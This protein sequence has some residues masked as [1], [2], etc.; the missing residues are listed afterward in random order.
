MMQFLK[1]FLNFAD[2]HICFI[3][4]LNLM[5]IFLKNPIY[6]LLCFIFAVINIVAIFIFFEADFIALIFFLVYVGA[7]AVLFLALIMFL[8]LSYLFYTDSFVSKNKSVNNYLY[9]CLFVILVIFSINEVIT[10]QIIIPQISNLSLHHFGISYLSYLMYEKNS[11]LIIF[12]GFLLF[13]TTIL[14]LA[15]TTLPRFQNM[16]V[17]RNILHRERIYLKILD[18]EIQNNRTK[19]ASR[20]INEWTEP[21]Y[22]LFE[23]FI[24]YSPTFIFIG[25]SFFVI[26]VVK[27]D[28]DIFIFFVD[29]AISICLFAIYMFVILKAFFKTN[30]SKRKLF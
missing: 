12:S 22:T 16:D 15:Y 17:V 19:N 24:L 5:V 14:T 10:I 1:D 18:L 8:N 27:N 2:L 11:I 23:K 25:L 26:Y 3:I 28:V 7:I 9:I 29:H 21:S 13:L 4:L 6:A 30:K 20:I